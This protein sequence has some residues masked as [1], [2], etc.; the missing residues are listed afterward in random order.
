[1]YYNFTWFLEIRDLQVLKGL[2][3]Q[4]ILTEV[5]LFVHRSKLKFLQF[6]L[7]GEFFILILPF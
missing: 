4:D 1:M 5:H 6:I 7:M 3:L 2:A